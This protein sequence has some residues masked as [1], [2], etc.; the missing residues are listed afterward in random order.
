M[1]YR[2]PGNRIHQLQNNHK[3]AI[4]IFY[5]GYQITLTTY[6][7][8][9][10]DVSQVTTRQLIALIVLN[11]KMI[12]RITTPICSW[13]QNRPC[14]PGGWD[15]I[16]SPP[17]IRATLVYYGQK[18]PVRISLQVC[19][20]APRGSTSSSG[21]WLHHMSWKKHMLD[22][23]T[24]VSKGHVIELARGQELANDQI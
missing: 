9:C 24:L 5:S 6:G 7:V 18:R 15:G 11:G 23:T 17:S 20:D 13:E 1:E 12:S 8:R 19:S 16:T 21:G 10:K 22:F 4:S 14:C 3:S 2:Y